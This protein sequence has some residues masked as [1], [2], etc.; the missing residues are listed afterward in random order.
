MTKKSWQGDREENTVEITGKIH[1]TSSS[2]KAILF[3][4]N[5]HYGSAKWIALSQI[6]I[7]SRSSRMSVIE[8]PEWIAKQNG[9][10]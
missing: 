7:V 10:I 5:D 1:S 6:E 8:V 4:D 2:G 3:S 9:W